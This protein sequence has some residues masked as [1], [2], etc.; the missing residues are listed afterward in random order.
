VDCG[1]GWRGFIGALIDWGGGLV[2]WLGL[3]IVLVF[4]RSRRNVCRFVGRVDSS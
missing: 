4:R 3:R 2:W 1:E